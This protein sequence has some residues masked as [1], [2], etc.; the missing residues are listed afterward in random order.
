[1][2]VGALDFTASDGMVQR[3]LDANTFVSAAMRSPLSW[4]LLRRKAQAPCVQLVNQSGCLVRMRMRGD[5]QVCVLAS[6]ER[7]I[8][9]LPSARG[10]EGTTGGA[11]GGGSGVTDSGSSGGGAATSASVDEISIEAG[12]VWHILPP[13]PSGRFGSWTLLALPRSPQQAQAHASA[14][15]YV[16]EPVAVQCKVRP[17]AD[18]V[19]ASGG[20]GLS[21]TIRSLATVHN[22][23]ST[24][25]GIQ[26]LLPT[27]AATNATADM[28]IGLE[29]GVARQQP[30][31]AH[32]TA[33]AMD[34]GVERILE[35]GI[36]TPGGS[37][38][39]P[40]HLANVAYLRARPTGATVGEGPTAGGATIDGDAGSDASRPLVFQW[41]EASQSFWLGSCN[42]TRRQARQL[43]RLQALFSLPPREQLV[44]SWSCS[45]VGGSPSAAGSAGGA[46]SGGSGGG[47]GR[48]RG[49]LYL[50][51][52]S[53]AFLGSRDV[54]RIMRLDTVTALEK[55]SADRAIGVRSSAA[56]TARAVGAA[57]RDQRVGGEPPMVVC[58][59]KSR[60]RTYAALQQHLAPR[61]P[62][63]ALTW[64]SPSSAKLQSHLHLPRDVLCLGELSVSSEGIRGVLLLTPRVIGFVAD[65][66]AAMTDDNGAEEGGAS[67]WSVE[68][69]ELIRVRAGGDS[70]A[71]GGLMKSRLRSQQSQALLRMH[72]RA[73]E[74]VL[75]VH[76]PMAEAADLL[77]GLLPDG[78]FEYDGWGGGGGGGTSG[79]TGG[80]G[81]AATAGHAD[82]A[83]GGDDGAADEADFGAEGSS[84][85]TDTLTALSTD[86]TT[87]FVACC[88]VQSRS[89]PL[90]GHARAAARGGK[91]GSTTATVTPF[92]QQ[93]I[94][95]L[96]APL[97][98]E[99]SLPYAVDVSLGPTDAAVADAL[100]AST[101]GGASGATFTAAK[102][103]EAWTAAATAAAA[104]VSPCGH[105]PAGGASPLA[106]LPANT[107]SLKL[108]LRMGGKQWGQPIAEYHVRGGMGT[109]GG[110]GGWRGSVASHCL[111]R[112]PHGRSAHV[113][114]QRLSTPSAGSSRAVLALQLDAPLWVMNHTQMQLVYS[115][116]TP[117]AAN[118]RA[119]MK[120][121]KKLRRKS[122]VMAGDSE[123][124]GDGGGGALGGGG[125]SGGRGGARATAKAQAS[126]VFSRAKV[127]AKSAKAGAAMGAKAGAIGAKAGATVASSAATAA[128]P[129]TTAK[130]SSAVK[131][132][133]AKASAGAAKATAVASSAGMAAA[134][135]GMAK[136]PPG[137]Q[138]A[139]QAA[140]GA[141]GNKMSALRGKMGGRMGFLRGMRKGEEMAEEVV[142]P[143]SFVQNLDGLPPRPSAMEEEQ[144]EGEVEDEGVDLPWEVAEEQEQEQ[145]EAVEEEEE[146]EE[147]EESEEGEEGEEGAEEE[148]EGVDATEEVS[149]SSSTLSKLVSGV[150]R[151]GDE[152]TAADASESDSEEE[153]EEEEDD[154]DEDDDDA[155]VELADDSQLVS[156]S[157]PAS[158]APPPCLAAGAS[159]AAGDSLARA[160]GFGG[161]GK[162]AARGTPGPWLLSGKRLKVALGGG[163]LKGR[164]SKALTCE[165]VGDTWAVPLGRVEIGLAVLEPP[166]ASP[167][168]RLVL[169]HPRYRVLNRSGLD[170]IFR[171]RGGHVGGALGR[172]DRRS[173]PFHWGDTPLS[174]R[175]LQLAMIPPP[176]SANSSA[177][178]S[179][180][181]ATPGGA[182]AVPSTGS[183][184]GEEW[185]GAFAIDIPTELV[186]ALPN[187]QGRAP[188]LVQVTNAA[189]HLSRDTLLRSTHLC[190]RDMSSQLFAPLRTPLPSSRPPPVFRSRWRLWA[191][192]CSCASTLRIPPPIEFAT[193]LLIST[194]P[195]VRR[196][197]TTLRS[198]RQEARSSTRGLSRRAHACCS[199]LWCKR[200]E[201]A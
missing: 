88:S 16:A 64:R 165:V 99:S 200:M 158:A 144:E 86:G 187:G 74:C 76:S 188:K 135:A 139:A 60:N 116:S 180:A 146:E 166:A 28:S 39:I 94:L 154:E 128:A 72:T 12:G 52:S 111:L 175:F 66:A 134:T 11:D 182:L 141:A 67:V 193:T 5:E 150:G 40:P 122:S 190:T 171:S 41:P 183:A 191:L 161:R 119:A 31:L 7:K 174:E 124:V 33:S 129:V 114:L 58:G 44:A 117:S 185:G 59:F 198:S 10:G 42:H 142:A 151:A 105:V 102:S 13:L 123:G 79:A 107:P 140:A 179:S 50:T 127:F 157:F 56:I 137:A 55:G 164:W 178:A 132:G 1:M 30:V 20:T 75:A 61:L 162:D 71:A 83:D 65:G 163:G 25:I 87:T 23:T 35:L 4:E 48:V 170:L 82:T 24:A 138:V 92:V 43:T 27:D 89:V 176:P 192:H 196:G 197:P 201:G 96:I 145:E 22:S 69:E 156:A 152:R 184:P 199:L 109:G 113:T 118:T 45:L 143:V 167:R 15:G 73:F 130:A 38:P 126:A 101:A 36:V 63:L 77:D 125:G 186:L 80:G 160:S 34:I 46:A 112:D 18:D 54:R 181:S 8:V 103:G 195:S 106:L 155:E 90:H 26:L 131:A 168:S 108:R 84:A 47:S 97:T 121:H 93:T 177:S 159:I 104:G 57:S 70:T 19:G 149:T 32:A 21:I 133:K 115:A 172:D 29:T 81:G 9:E 14:A 85:I 49:R 37:L 110:D 173:V 68:V 153:S 6:G 136:L 100:I 53:L 148:A 120:Q 62:Q 147:G 78:V 3:I 91:G 95:S 17:M 2:E 98:I 189:Q 194:W 169:I 51:S